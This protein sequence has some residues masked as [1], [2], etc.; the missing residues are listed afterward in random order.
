MNSIPS[1]VPKSSTFSHPDHAAS[2]FI[3]TTLFIVGRIRSL[4]G[5]AAGPGLRA[6]ASAGRPLKL[7]DILDRQK[8]VV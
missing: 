8:K 3:G 6:L 7:E 4:H 2:P 5:L 1:A